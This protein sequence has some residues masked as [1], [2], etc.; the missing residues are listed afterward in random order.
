M[1]RS[2]FTV[3]AALAHWLATISLPAPSIQTH[4]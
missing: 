3:L 2:V 1:K 4:G